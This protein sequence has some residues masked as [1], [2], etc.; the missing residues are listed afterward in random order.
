[1]EGG[2][3][4][5]EDPAVGRGH[6]VPLARGGGHGS[7]HR[8]VEFGLRHVAVECGVAVGQDPPPVGED[9]VAGTGR[10]RREAGRLLAGGQGGGAGV[11]EVDGVAVGVDPAGVVENPVALSVGGGLEVDG[12]GLAQRAVRVAVVDR[13]AES[14][15]LAVGAHHPVAGPDRAGPAA[16]RTRGLGAV[17]ALVATGRSGSRR[18]RGRC[19]R[20]RW[21]VCAAGI[22]LDHGYVGVC[23][24]AEPARRGERRR[25]RPNPGRR[26]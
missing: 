20:G 9:P 11:A 4:E 1:M 24:E 12:P 18:R 13:I 8:T 3:A 21:G 5:G 7:Q 26:S 22:R 16:W 17:A 25:S 15:H 14:V 2:V 10:R 23:R 6:V 19:G